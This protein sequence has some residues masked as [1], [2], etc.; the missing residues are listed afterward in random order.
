MTMK[1]KPQSPA[2]LG[3]QR[4]PASRGLFELSYRVKVVTPVFGGGVRI[5]PDEP[6][7]KEID[8]VTPFRGNTI[9]GHLR[10]WWR[11]T[12]GCRRESIEDM[13]KAERKL[14]GGMRDDSV[15]IGPNV[16]IQVGGGAR[17]GAEVS[18]YYKDDPKRAMNMDLGYA[19]FPLQPG[20]N[21]AGSDAGTLRQVEGEALIIIRGPKEAEAEVR[22]AVEAW[23]YL[24]G[25][26]GRTRRGFGSLECERLSDACAFLDRWA[27]TIASPTL[28]LVPA[29]VGVT[30]R[31]ARGVARTADKAQQEGLK[32]M[33][34]FRQGPGVARNQGQQHNH[35]GRSLW[36]EPDAIR[37]LTGRHSER[38][39]PRQGAA[40]VFPRGA[41][42]MP[43]IFHFKDR[44]EPG[45]TTLKPS[46][47]ERMASPIILRPVRVK[48]GYLPAAVR[49]SV[50]QGLAQ[51]VVLAGAGL[52]QP[53]P[54]RLRLSGT[55]ETRLTLLQS[56][57]V[58]GEF[59]E[60][61][62]GNRG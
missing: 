38:H 8:P 27:E 54:V 23:I 49:L 51:A 42:G 30:Y 48:G 52:N 46:D 28:A 41:F 43:V 11:A 4:T 7:R 21:A 2:P 15:Q 22:D 35:P 62:A 32:L 20:K 18:V 36:P 33:R 6:H 29:L 24:G 19:A 12:H 34:Q 60:F 40:K 56:T 16:T 31:K 3:R 37:Q 1:T 25:I 53:I 5:D 9:R 39:V 10:F 55:N 45:D 50:P 58:L 59:L 13:F 47:M 61:F 26:G 44:G 14:W 57:D 17:V